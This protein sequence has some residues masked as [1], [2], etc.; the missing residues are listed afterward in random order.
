VIDALCDLDARV[1][2][3]PVRHHSPA[4]ARRVADLVRRMRPAAV[5]IEGPSDFN[6]R[7][8][9]LFLPHRLPIA[10][11]SY[12]RL[13]DERR[14]GA[15][16]PFCI[17]SPEWQALLAARELGAVA[18]FIDLPWSDVARVDET[19]NRYA[20]HGLRRGEYVRRLCRQTGVE[21]FDD[22][23]DRFFELEADLDLPDFLRRCHHFCLH[24]RLL[25]DEVRL[26]D[27]RREAFMAQQVRHALEEF[28]GRILVVTGGYHSSAIHAR[29]TGATV[30]GSDDPPDYQ[31]EAL[32]D[33]AER[34]IA[35]TPYSYERLDSLRGYDAG[36]PNPGFYH[37]VWQDA[38]EKKSASHRR[39]LARVVGVLRKRGQ[40]ISAADLIA[41]ETTACGLAQLRGH[42]SVWRQDL[43][44]GIIG[45]LIK[46]ERAYGIGHALLDAVHEVFRGGER[47]VLA[48]GTV[49]PPLVHD[50]RQ[51]LT[52]HELEPQ[53][54]QREVDLDLQL[55]LDRERSR[56]M[57]RLRILAIAGFERI[58]G[59]DLVTRTDLS[60]VW[61]RWR[62]RWTPDFDA[63]TIEA[64]R[65]GAA[66]A[67][68]AAARL[69][70]RAGISE[71][72]AEEAALLLLD[73]SLAGLIDLADEF[74]KQLGDLVRSDNDFFTVT[75]SLGHLL[76]L[77][78]H[79]H[80]LQTAGR[81]DLAALVLETFTRG[82]W[83]LESLGQVAGRDK[84]LLS[85][86][87]TLL[88]AFERCAG[89]LNIN[90]DEF[91]AVLQRV[92]SEKRQSPLVRG[93]SSGALWTI[94]E[95]D[96]DRV[97]AQMLLFADPDCL[98]DFLAGLFCM[99]REVVQR[100]RELVLSID[101][102]LVAYADEEFLTALPSL[103]L[104]FT[105]FTPREKHH[106]GLTLVEALGLKE[107]RPLT[108]LEETPETM[109]RALAFESRLFEAVA[110]YGL[111]GGQS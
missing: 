34:G 36:M 51:L 68:A 84:D 40:Q 72:N 48:E 103:R 91:V 66:L 25:D 107:Q 20:D 17:Y 13:A 77:Y 42:A 28:R 50:L 27:R 94:G 67:D 86:I 11:Y 37:Q 46:E 97:F 105:Y 75:K 35:L 39:L 78:V 73:A 14:R 104:A 8:D 56:L 15:Y 54:K 111:R 3:F 87:R 93:A 79:D 10:I 26:A 98:G 95:S 2:C 41:A 1:V 92:G 24:T 81:A 106:M 52:R 19:A 102:L 101:K 60:K 21:N 32:T 85:G 83:L 74:L 7:L 4:C 61:E 71:R 58:D 100:H 49:L 63:T 70:E 69:A 80:V 96:A 109:S 16:Y 62:I 88:D 99:A 43:V 9:E 82:M 64:A 45:A 59:A 90:R 65:Y 30:A 55:E 89:T 47:G 110:R 6:D 108:Q 22:L 57:H 44:D 38:V 53:M 5:L 12:V 29:L 76:Y 18:R 23:W 31:P 33:C